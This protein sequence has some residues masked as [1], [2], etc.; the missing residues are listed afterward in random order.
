MASR[1]T[2][3]Q[4]MPEPAYLALRAEILRA[5]ALMS[6]GQALELADLLH[7][8]IRMRKPCRR[9]RNLEDLFLGEARSYQVA[10]R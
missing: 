4:S 10:S 9:L 1:P 6:C 3:E 2:S 8:V 5:S 7:T